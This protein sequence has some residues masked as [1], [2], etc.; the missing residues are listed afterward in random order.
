MVR[1][2]KTNLKGNHMQLLTNQQ[3]SSIQKINDG[4]LALTTTDD[5]HITIENQFMVKPSNESPTAIQI[6]QDQDAAFSALSKMIVG[7]QIVEVN[8]SHIPNNE[9]IKFSNGYT[10]ELAVHAVC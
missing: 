5:L 9:S 6:S 3:V 4:L 2:M 10:L 1:N 7:S 8:D